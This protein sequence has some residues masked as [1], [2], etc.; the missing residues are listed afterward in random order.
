MPLRQF[1]DGLAFVRIANSGDLRYI[2]RYSGILVVHMLTL[3]LFPHFYIV[4][5]AFLEANV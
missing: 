1:I 2:L 5:I 4:G 3:T